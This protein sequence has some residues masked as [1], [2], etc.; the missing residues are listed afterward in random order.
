MEEYNGSTWT[1][2]TDLPAATYS[3]GMAGT[4]TAGLFFQG[5]SPSAASV[6][7]TYEYDGTNWTDGG[8]CNVAKNASSGCGTQ[9][10]GLSMFGEP[11]VSSDEYNGTA[12]T[13]G[14][15]GNTERYGVGGWGTQTAAGVAGG[16]G[17]GYTNITELYDGSSWTEVADLSTSR[18]NLGSG[19]NGAQTAGLV[20][21]GDRPANSNATEE[22]TGEYAAAATV[23]SS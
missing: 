16:Y 13:A 8:D 21:G 11:G 17:P 15:N 1:E 9:T 23:T 3:A 14:G 2:V 6:A 10:A 22:F 18:A 12:W 7:E 4:Q 20:F 19:R 5:N